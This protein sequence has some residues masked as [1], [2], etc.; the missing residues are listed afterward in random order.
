M[1]APVVMSVYTRLEHFKKAITALQENSLAIKSNL[2]I[3][4]DAASCDSDIELVENVRLH[5]KTIDGFRT[6]TLIE[7]PHNMGG[8]NN[9]LRGLLQVVKIFKKAIFLEDDIV[10]APGFLAFMNQALEFYKDDS[11]VTSI[12]GYSPPLNIT[13]FVED[14]FYVMN[15]FCGWGSAL[16]ERTAKLLQK[17]ITQEEFDN[18]LDKSVLCEFGDDVLRMVEKEVKGELDAADVRC[19]FQQA[20]HGTATIY[21]R[22]SLVQNRGHDGSGYHCGITKRFEHANLWEKL[23]GFV[24][25]KNFSMDKRIAK[26][27]RDFRAFKGEYIVHRTISNQKQSKEVALTYISSLFKEDLSNMD[28]FSNVTHLKSSKVAILSTPRVGSTFLCH[29]LYQYFGES[30]RREWLHNRYIDAFTSLK[31]SDSEVEYLDFLKTKAF[32]DSESL[33]LH[34]HV[35]QVKAWNNNFNI[36]IL[37]YYG[38]DNIIYMRR[39]D[40][41]AQSFSLAIATESGLWGSEII[42]A[43]NFAEGFKVKVSKEAFDKAYKAILSEQAYFEKHLE[44]KVTHVIEYEELLKNPQGYINQLFGDELGLRLIKG[45]NNLAMPEK[46]FSIVCDENKET[47]KSYFNEKYS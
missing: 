15:R 37:D 20:I 36:D 33:G 17:K 18:L 5:A 29:Q 26:E 1:L 47:L 9:A 3:F 31:Q 6:V 10:T 46:S 30:I 14:D 32:S 12:T 7:R 43:L 8:V 42:K 45:N 28:L 2:I 41:F 35:N 39:K 13:E 40:L 11:S 19:M 16:F 27:Q 25:H 44:S 38:F 22:H 21:P 23:D 34:I 24:F 4:S